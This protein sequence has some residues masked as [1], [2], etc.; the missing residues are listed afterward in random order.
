[1]LRGPNCQTRILEYL[2]VVGVTLVGSLFKIGPSDLHTHRRDFVLRV[3]KRFSLI[4]VGRDDRWK[5]RFAFTSDRVVDLSR[6]NGGV[7][8]EYTK[9]C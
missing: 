2:N 1:M 9:K 8:A 6:R 3:T 7:C 5:S 4:L